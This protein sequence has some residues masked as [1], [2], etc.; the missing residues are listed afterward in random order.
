[1]FEFGGGFLWYTVNDFDLIGEWSLPVTS[2]CEH[3]Q[4]CRPNLT[5]GMWRTSSHHSTSILK[6]S[7]TSIFLRSTLNM[8]IPNRLPLFLIRFS[9]ASDDLSNGRHRHQC[10]SKIVSWRVGEY[11]T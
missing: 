8:T 3:S 9:P 10:E 11:F 5:M 4:G 6:D 7:H 2:F 1:M